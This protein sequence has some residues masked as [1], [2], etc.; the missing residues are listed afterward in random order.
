MTETCSDEH[1]WGEMEFPTDELIAQGVS[2][3]PTQ[4]CTRCGARRRILTLDDRGRVQG[5]TPISPAK[6]KEQTNASQSNSEG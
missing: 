3:Y 6:P 2:P 5:W 1:P 4:T